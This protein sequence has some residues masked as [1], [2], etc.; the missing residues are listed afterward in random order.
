MLIT[1]YKTN[2]AGAVSYYS[3]HDRQGNLFSPNSFTVHWGRELDRGRDYL[4]S[5][6]TRQEMDLR[7]QNLIRDKIRGGYKVLYSYFRGNEGENLKPLVRR[8]YAS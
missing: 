3:L 8:H 2:E 6:E 1:L 4:Y 7:I 5:F